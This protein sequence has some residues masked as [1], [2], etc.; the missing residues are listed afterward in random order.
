[1]P[2]DAALPVFP[3]R[4]DWS[5]GIG[6]R[7]AFRTE[8]LQARAGDEQTRALLL[9]PRRTFE[10]NLVALAG[11]RQLLGSRLWAVRSGE[12]YLPIP[13]DGVPLEVELSAGFVM[14]TFGGADRDFSDGGA[15]VFL[16][17]VTGEAEA[18]E[19]VSWSPGSLS[20]L[21]A[22]SSRTWPVGTMVYPARRAR[23]DGEFAAAAF[24]GAVG[25]GRVRLW[26]SE[27]CDWT[28]TAPAV[29]YRDFPVLTTRPHTGR[30]PETAYRIDAEL[31]DEGL[32]AASYFDYVGAPLTTQAHDFWLSGRAAIA[33]FRSVVYYLQGRH[34]SL[35]VPTWLDD[36]T[37]AASLG[38]SST[39]L[40]VNHCEYTANLFG[41]NNRK[42]LRIELKSGAVYYRRVTASSVVSAAVEELTLSSS[43][44]VAIAPG[45]VLQISFLQLCRSNADLFNFDWWTS[46]FCEVATAWRGRKHEQ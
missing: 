25:E 18:F 2:F 45:D 8:A 34:K 9:A 28:A 17:P 33:E 4:A 20:E 16:D 22:A 38:S 14:A 15:V 19:L 12:W 3:F 31:V 35:W 32:G 39:A 21:G 1:M 40:Q 23:L 30:D 5:A 44:G 13:T 10:F 43:L 24:T 37:I 36:L 46:E 26:I 42:D 6:E 7:L 29:T 27:P 11:A 41:A